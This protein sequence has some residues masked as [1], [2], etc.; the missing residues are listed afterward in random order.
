[1]ATAP[2]GG[3]RDG[4]RAVGMAGSGGRGYNPLYVT[5]GGAVSGLRAVWEIE[6]ELHKLADIVTD[7]ETWS[8]AGPGR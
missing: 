3:P 6:R 5:A 1:M 4:K 7:H 2:P 8:G